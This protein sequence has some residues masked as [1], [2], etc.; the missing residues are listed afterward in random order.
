MPVP[1]LSPAMRSIFSWGCSSGVFPFPSQSGPIWSLPC[2]IF[3]FPG[4]VQQRCVWVLPNG[5]PEVSAPWPEAGRRGD[6]HL[7][8]GILVLSSVHKL[9]VCWGCFQHGC[10]TQQQDIRLAGE[11]PQS[12][13]PGKADSGSRGRE[14]G[15]EDGLGRRRTGGGWSPWKRNIGG[16]PS[17]H[18]DGQLGYAHVWCGDRV[19]AVCKPRSIFT[20]A[21]SQMEEDGSQGISACPLA[22]GH[23]RQF[24][25]FI[26]VAILITGRCGGTGCV[27]FATVGWR[28]R[29]A[30]YIPDRWEC[31]TPACSMAVTS[32][33]KIEIE[34]FI[35]NIYGY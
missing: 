10:R 14:V 17:A 18:P 23:V 5:V 24:V 6:E 7:Q 34:S 8:T 27:L 22:I 4:D 1:A 11:L 32:C 16:V 28:Q 15:Q 9:P 3:I 13:I 12:A 2:G 25:C 31:I 33:S 30:A 26:V 35:F 21:T 20:P 19:S 29:P